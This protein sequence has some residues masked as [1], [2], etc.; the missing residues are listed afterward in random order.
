MRKPK[1]NKVSYFV[2]RFAVLLFVCTLVSLAAPLSWVA[3]LFS[4]FVWQYAVLAAVCSGLLLIAGRVFLAIVMLAVVAVNA[5]ALLPFYQKPAQ[6]IFDTDDTEQVSILQYNVNQ[7]NEDKLAAADFLKGEAP[8]ADIMV[9]F[10]ID[11]NWKDVID[12]LKASYPYVVQANAF[13]T[14]TRGSVILSKMPLMEENNDTLQIADS[15]TVAILRA[16]TKQLGIPFVLY[17]VHPDSPLSSHFEVDRD[18]YLL[19]AGIALS[20]EPSASHIMVGD[21]NT[22]R[23]APVFQ[24]LLAVSDLADSNVGQGYAGTWPAFLPSEMGIPIDNL[25]ISKNMEVESKEVF[26][27]SFGSDHYPVLT[28]LKIEQ[29][30]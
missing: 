17:A 7:S 21:F 18:R 27:Q 20:A 22:T 30:D 10:E 1:P 29:I 28:K 9:L 15:A 13:D 12:Q 3:E 4:H 14:K 5:Y 8:E 2:S 19:S 11:D 26:H 25:L 6:A 23:F 24:K 16:Q